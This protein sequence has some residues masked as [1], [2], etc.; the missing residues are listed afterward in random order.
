MEFP[1]EG[2]WFIGRISRKLMARNMFLGAAES[3]TGG[4]ASVL[5]TNVPGSSLWFR[6]GIVTYADALKTSLLNVSP[7][8]LERHG[9]V[10]GPVV[11]AMAAGILQATGATAGL[12]ISG[13]AGPDGGTPEKPVGA[14]WIATAVC[15]PFAPG[16]ETKGPILAS[17]LH[18]FT[19]YREDIRIKAALAAL[20]A[21]DEAL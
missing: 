16:R 9:A 17:V 8:L 2:L 3:C 12:A 6:G 21:L 19:G 15:L 11:E 7:D 13:V 14:V 18:H 5:C 4:L 10:S 20:K 1:E